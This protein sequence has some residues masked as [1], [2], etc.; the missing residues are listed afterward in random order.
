M[1]RLSTQGAVSAKKTIHL[2]PED[3][4]FENKIE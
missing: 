4:Y 3:D 1:S 2:P